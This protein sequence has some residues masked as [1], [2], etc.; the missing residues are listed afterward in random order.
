MSIVVHVSFLVYLEWNSNYKGI[1]MLNCRRQ[2]ETVIQSHCLDLH[3]K[4][5]LTSTLP[6]LI[7]IFQNQMVFNDNISIYITDSY[8]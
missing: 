4:K 7:I 5:N 2:F 6:T 8:L 3:H 1:Q